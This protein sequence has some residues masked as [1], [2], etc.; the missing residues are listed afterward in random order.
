MHHVTH[1]T[2]SAHGP[3]ITLIPGTEFGGSK[4]RCRIKAIQTPIDG[5][6]THCPQVAVAPDLKFRRMFTRYPWREK[7]RKS[8]HSITSTFL[9]SDRQWQYL[10][11][12][13]RRQKHKE[14]ISSNLCPSITSVQH[15]KWVMPPHLSRLLPFQSKQKPVITALHLLTAPSQARLLERLAM[16]WKCSVPRMLDKQSSGCFNVIQGN[17]NSWRTKKK[18]LKSR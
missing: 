11:C 6:F 2:N 10:V 16:E 12:K 7:S 1:L 15:R 18:T 3:H 4:Q 8:F 9:M 14:D 13:R 5:H 17:G